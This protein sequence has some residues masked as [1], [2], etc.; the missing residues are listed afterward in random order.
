M[1]KD[2]S[3]VWLVLLVAVGWALQKGWFYQTGQQWFDSCWASVNANGRSA[4]SP[5]E[6]TAWAQCGPVVDK[7]LFDA[8]YVF[9]GNPQ[10]AVIPQ[11]HALAAACPSNYTDIPLAGPYSLAVSLIQDAG[12]PRWLDRF[13]PPGRM[14]VKVFDARWPQCT[15]ER[16][17]NGFPKIVMISGKWDFESHCVPCDAELKAM[18]K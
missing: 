2:A 11:L 7:A 3:V 8:G 6:A 15:V 16:V 10:Y 9:S 14:I 5:E 4:A 12:G 13:L 1:R 18:G 17:R